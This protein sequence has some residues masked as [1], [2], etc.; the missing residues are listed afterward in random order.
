MQHIAPTPATVA[1]GKPVAWLAVFAV[2]LVG[3]AAW[4][5]FMPHG[6]P[7]LH[8]RC[9]A[10]LICPLLFAAVGAAGCYA[11][12]R[13][14]TS[15]A[16]AIMLSLAVLWTAALI[17]AVILFPVS[18]PSFRVPLAGCVVVL[19]LVYLLGPTVQRTPV[20]NLAASITAAIVVG[21]T[22]PWTQ[23]APEPQTVPCNESLAAVT[24]GGRNDTEVL[25][26]NIS[27]RVQV[28]ATTGDIT[29]KCGPL[30]IDIA[31]LLT[32]ESRSPDRCWTVL[33]P[34]SGNGPLRRL[35]ALDVAQSSVS[36]GFAGDARHILRVA[37][38]DAETAGTREACSIESFT[39]LDA[40]VYSHLNSYATI[41]VRGHQR[42][43]LGFSPC[44]EVYVSA[45]PADY[46]VGRPSRFA[47]LDS[48]GQFHVV[49]ASSGEKGP[50]HEIARGPLARAESLT[51]TLC[52]RGEPLAAIVCED[53]A[54][55]ASVDLSPTAGWGAPMNSIEFSR[56]G[57][58]ASA[59]VD[60]WL[61]LAA[62]SVGRGW[63]S[64]GHRAGTYRNR[65]RL[66]GPLARSSAKPE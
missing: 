20:R 22:L 36:L 24:P 30:M 11:V 8:A 7:W 65:M 21:V 42:L 2:H 29:A 28:L 27:D 41:T 38:N 60:I 13:Q 25:L 44:P 58:A 9:Y 16:D 49:Q 15:L 55:Q 62:T 52:D 14:R 19:W 39:E 61:S 48:V 66:R 54:S 18:A 46:P 37:V 40:P 17:T 50:F 26:C 33:A 56:S 43:T 4:W 47:Y 45:E 3:A 57:D 1:R 51:I 64:V 10:N 23:R 35:V 31:P 5:W 32:F 12:E 53:W 63:D 6:F 34:R 59:N